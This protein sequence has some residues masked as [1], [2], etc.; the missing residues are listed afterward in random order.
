MPHTKC[1]QCHFAPPQWLSETSKEAVVDYYRCEAC[2][3]VWHVPKS[4]PDGP[5]TSVTVPTH[6]SGGD[7]TGVD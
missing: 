4:H 5:I 1:P 3:H 6:V 7:P 2:G